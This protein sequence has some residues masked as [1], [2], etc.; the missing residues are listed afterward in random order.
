M[1]P[2]IIGFTGTHKGMTSDQ[3]F[4][5]EYL[6]S[7]VDFLEA[8]HGDCIGADAQFH[9]FCLD[10]KIPIVIHPPD[11]KRKRAFC[12]AEHGREGLGTSLPCKPYLARNRDI[13]NTC[14]ILI[15]CPKNKEE[16]LRSGTWA[17]IRHAKKSMKGLCLIYPDG[18]IYR[19][20]KSARLSTPPKSSW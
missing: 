11:D 8:H 13:V 19:I 20:S 5:V 18:E 10:M 17:T 3:Y 2:Q 6:L 1:E 9:L 4:A 14:D 7:S 15:A 16:E 12:F